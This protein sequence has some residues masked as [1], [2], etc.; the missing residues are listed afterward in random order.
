MRHIFRS[1][2]AALFYSCCF[3]PSPQRSP[4]HTTQ[5]AFMRLTN[6]SIAGAGLEKKAFRNLIVR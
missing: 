6:R 2:I 1:R 3:P 5:E 4:Y